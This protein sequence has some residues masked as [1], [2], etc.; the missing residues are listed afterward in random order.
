MAVNPSPFGPKPQFEL[1]TGAP[2]VGGQLFFYVAGSVNTK[3]NTYTDSTGGVANTNPIILNSLGQPTNE[4]WFAAGQAYKVVFAPA[5][6][7]DPPSSPIWSIDNL[8][9]INDSSVTVDQWVSSGITPTFV[10]TTQFTMPGDQTSN[11]AVGRRVKCTVTAGTVYGRISVSAYAALTTVTLVMDGVS[12]LDAGLSAVSYGLLSPGNMSW[13]PTLIQAGTNIT[14]TYDSAGRPVIASAAY[15]PQIQPISASVGSNALTISASALSLDF[16]STTLTSGTVTT[17]SGTPSNLV[18]SSGSTLG[19]VNATAARIAVLAMNNAGTIELAV[20]NLAGGNN[21]DETT[22]ISTTAE[23]GAGAADSANVIY[24][25]TARTNVAFRVIGFLDCTEATAGTWATAPST[26]QGAGGQAFA[27]MSS[28]GYGQT[29]QNVTRL[30]GTTYYNTTG[31]PILA[32]YY[33][34][35]STGGCTLQ[36]TIDGQTVSGSGRDSVNGFSSIVAII[37]P[38]RSYVLSATA[39]GV[40][41]QGASIQELR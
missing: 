29:W 39:G 1:A 4:I 20:V 31:R 26:I 27:G 9:G 15:P 25:T 16:R 7:T 34:S 17:V 19:T 32:S 30:L 8:R 12:V 2:N 38:G 6:D 28:L 3:Q 21:L 14:I 18:I 22:L 41:T 11:F 37:P 5:G 33:G 24:S 13:P 35:T 23:G 36:L 10:S 40:L